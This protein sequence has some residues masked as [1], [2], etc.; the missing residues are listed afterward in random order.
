MVEKARRID[1]RGNA[2]SVVSPD[3]TAD[4][5]AGRKLAQVERD[6]RLSNLRQADIPVVDWDVEVP[7]A[8]VLAHTREQWSG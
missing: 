4:G 2:V 7:L 8:K 1:A 5:S 6:K 3:V